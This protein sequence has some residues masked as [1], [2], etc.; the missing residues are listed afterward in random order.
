M[1]LIP[2]H[3]W[4]AVLLCLQYTAALQVSISLCTNYLAMESIHGS[5]SL[6]FGRFGIYLER[7]TRRCIRSVVYVFGLEWRERHGLLVLPIPH[8]KM[9]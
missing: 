9:L 1:S 6:H 4:V 8:W 5:M 7:N 3:S 2:A